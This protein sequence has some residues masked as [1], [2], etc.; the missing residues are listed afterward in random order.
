MSPITRTKKV[1]IRSTR[2]FDPRPLT[3][4]GLPHTEPPRRS[5][6]ELSYTHTHTHTHGKHPRRC[7]RARAR[8]GRVRVGRK[9]CRCS[10]RNLADPCGPSVTVR[11]RAA[12]E[13]LITHVLEKKKKRYLSLG[14]G[15]PDVKA[16]A[17][18]TTAKV[19]NG[20]RAAAVLSSS[21]PPRVSR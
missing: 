1:M 6:S 7:L 11:G 13:I 10:R 17:V 3:G 16:R 2:F 18:S 12:F 5:P 4:G 21:P 9:L 20:R 15:R 14:S 19:F 8:E